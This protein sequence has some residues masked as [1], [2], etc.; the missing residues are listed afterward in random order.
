[1][2]IKVLIIDPEPAKRAAA[3]FRFNS[4][5]TGPV[6]NQPFPIQGQFLILASDKLDRT[7][8]THYGT[9]AA[10]FVGSG[11]FNW[12]QFRM[13]SA[14]SPPN[15]RLPKGEGEPEKKFQAAKPKMSAARQK[16]VGLFHRGHR[17]EL[18]NLVI[19]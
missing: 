12:W 19:D 16:F 3:D 9:S 8:L 13:R 4:D 2:T 7:T 18:R 10:H 15:P 14:P 17:E 6:M 5:A 1:M 11:K